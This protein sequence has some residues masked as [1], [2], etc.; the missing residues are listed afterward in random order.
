[1]YISVCMQNYDNVTMYYCMYVTTLLH[2]I[3]TYFHYMYP[4]MYVTQLRITDA[5]LICSTQWVLTYTGQART[6]G[7]RVTNTCTE[8]T[9]A[10]HGI[11]KG[12]TKCVLRLGD[13]RF[14][15]S[16]VILNE[17]TLYTSVYI[18]TEDCIVTV[19]LNFSVLYNNGLDIVI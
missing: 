1:M 6:A 15:A 18:D 4:D 7:K 5:L 19:L 12:R 16:S 10:C 3:T 11:P 9:G 14:V 2:V 17:S 13:T 8:T